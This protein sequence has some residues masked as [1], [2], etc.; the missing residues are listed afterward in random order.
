MIGGLINSYAMK[1]DFGCGSGSLLDSLLDHT[2]TLEKV[3]GVD[4]SRKSLIRA[5]KVQLVNV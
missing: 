5:A 1:V 2:T 4:I 3:A